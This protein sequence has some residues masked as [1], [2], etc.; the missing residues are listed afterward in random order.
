MSDNVNLGTAL[1]TGSSSGIGAL[2]A[3]RLAERGYDLILVARNRNKLN[4]IATEITAKTGRSV[5]AIPTDLTESYDLACVEEFLRSDPTITMLVNDAGF[6][7]TASILEADAASMEKMIKL[8]VTS[9]MALTYAAVPEFVKRGNGTII[10]ISSI[11]A[12]QPELLNGVYG[13]SK[14]FVLAFTQS[15]H[16]ELSA[17]GIRVQVVLPP[18]TRTE[19]FTTAG[20]PIDSMTEDRRNTLMSPETLV[21]A[22]LA[23]LDMG[24]VVTIPSLEEKVIWDAYE[25][26]R[27]QLIPKLRQ[28]KAAGRYGLRSDQ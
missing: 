7:S 1:I 13:G 2:Y 20:T 16:H 18:G 14:A 11:V 10:N 26:A 21:D 19:F 9:L 25:D 23:G 4:A 12:I 22:A 3:S 8:N 6:G 15:L 27:Q 24:E 17:K 5:Q 28:A